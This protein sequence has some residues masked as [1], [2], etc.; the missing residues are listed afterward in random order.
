MSFNR[1]A[2]SGSGVLSFSPAKWNVEWDGVSEAKASFGLV[3][4]GTGV[5]YAAKAYRVF[6]DD[7]FVRCANN[8]YSWQPG[9]RYYDVVNCENNTLAYASDIT[10]PATVSSG[11]ATVVFSSVPITAYVY[12]WSLVATKGTATRIMITGRLEAKEQNPYAGGGS[13]ISFVSGVTASGCL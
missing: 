7:G 4:Q 13:T 2:S 8:N 5:S 10:L 6:D 11:V 3:C 9:E 12:A 1:G